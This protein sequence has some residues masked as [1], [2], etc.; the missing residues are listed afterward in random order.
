M[1][2]DYQGKTYTLD[3]DAIQDFEVFEE[4]VEVQSG[5]IAPV[6]HVVKSLLGEEGYKTLKDS[7]RDE[8][9]RV[10]TTD[11]VKAF[12]CIM[13]AAGEDKKK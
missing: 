1:Q 10:R 3:D 2:V 5:N 9:G 11:F 13:A 7:L 12:G 8:N 6:I 4:V